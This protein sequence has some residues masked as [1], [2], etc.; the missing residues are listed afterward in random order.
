MWLLLERECRT[1]FFIRQLFSLH[2]QKR[3]DQFHAEWESAGVHKMFIDGFCSTLVIMSL[4]L[5]Q[6][7]HA[8]EKIIPNI[9]F[10]LLRSRL[11]CLLKKVVTCVFMPSRGDCNWEWSKWKRKS[12]NKERFGIRFLTLMAFQQRF[13]RIF[14]SILV[15]FTFYIAQRSGWWWWIP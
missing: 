3:S 1:F 9:H 2:H 4:T 14:I 12:D 15:N 11:R 5:T 7:L 13:S 10:L 8:S 6:T